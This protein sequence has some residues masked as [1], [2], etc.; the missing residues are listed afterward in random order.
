MLTDY[1]FMCFSGKVKC[2]F[3][4][5][6]RKSQSGLRVTFFDEEWNVLPFERQYRKSDNYIP[7]PYLYDKMVRVAEKLSAGFPFV[8]VDLYDINGQIY[9]GEITLYPGCGFEPF[10]PEEWDFKMGDLIELEGCNI[11]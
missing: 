3:T 8:R 2:S 11:R 7:K 10:Q 9:F 5:T 6:E 4:C 1:K